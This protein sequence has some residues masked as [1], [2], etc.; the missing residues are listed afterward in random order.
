[1]IKLRTLLALSPALLITQCAPEC[2]PA[3]E[4]PAAVEVRGGC[5]GIY[6]EMIAQGASDGVAQRFAYRIAPR[7]SGCTPQFVHD[8]DDWSYSRFGLNGIT[9]QLRNGWMSWC[10]ADVRWDTRILETDVHCALEGYARMG[11]APWQ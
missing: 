10:G 11:W 6:D 4:E 3:P 9:A 5:D 2:A 7:E 1:M 8:S